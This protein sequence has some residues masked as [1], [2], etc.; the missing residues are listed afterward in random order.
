M[1]KLGAVIG[2]SILAWSAAATET[3]A[4]QQGE[5]KGARTAM[6]FD[7]SRPLSEM[8]KDVPPTMQ[9]DF[10]GDM[11]FD[12]GPSD[13]IYGP[14]T[15]DRSV[16]ERVG[17]LAIPAPAA[18]FNVGVGTANPPDPVGDVGPNHYVRMANA[19]FQIF[20]KAGAPLSNSAPINTL[21]AG[22]GGACETENAGDPIVLYDQLAD[23]W[24]LTQFSDS[25]GP[26]FF[27]CVAL[28]TSPDPLGTY[29]RWAFMTPSFPDYPKYGVWSNAY[30]IST[31]EVNSSQIGAIGV[32][33]AAMIAGNPTPTLIEFRVPVNQFSGDGLLPTDIDGTRLPPTGAPAY[34]IGAMDN[35]GPYGATQDA[36]NVWELN[37]NFATPA[38]SSF[39]LVKTVAISPYDTIFP[40]NGRACIPQPNNLGGVDILSY[41]QR[42]TNRAA[43][44]N[45]GSYQSIVTNQSV[46]AG[47]GIAGVRWWEIRNPGAN[48]VLYQDSTF[49]PGLT[50]GVNRW[51]GSI[52]QDASGNTGLGYSSVSLTEFPGIRYTGRLEH[53]PL[54]Q[55]SQGEGVFVT[56]AGGLTA[57]TK[58]WGDYT[59]MNIDPTD[60][61][62]FWFIN[63]YFPTSGTQWTLRAGSFKFPDCG[64]PNFGVAAVP[65]T[66]TLC[67]GTTANITVDAHGYNGFAGTANLSVTGAPAGTTTSF[68]PA[69]IGSVPGSSTLSIAN[70]AGVTAGN[71]TL[72]ITGQSGAL[73]RSRSVDVQFVTANLLAPSL[74]APAAGATGVSVQPLLSWSAVAESQSYRVEVATDA[75]F[76]NI[77][78]TSAATT[79][80]SLQLGPILTGGTQYFWRVR[81]GNLCGQGAFA[82]GSFRTRPAPG[83]CDA[84]ERLVTGF[85]DNMESGL[86]GWTVSPATAP[87][88]SQSTT[89]ANSPVNSWFAPDVT[90][91]SEQLLISPPISIAATQTALSLRFSHRFDMEPNGAGCFDGG[92]VEFSNDNGTTWQ[93][94]P[95]SSVLEGFYTG[96]LGNGQPAWCGT[97]NTFGNVSFDVVGLAGRTV[98]LRFHQSTDSGVGSP[99]GWFVD[100]VRIEGCESLDVLLRNG[101]E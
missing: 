85:S 97:R 13:K 67:A 86:N 24:L 38:S 80:T 21:F 30:L 83:Q 52:A 55:M 94:L 66:Q 14:Q 33:R 37:L 92:Y 42:P 93:P 56:G 88:W 90:T 32:D 79:A 1:F 7:V 76:N 12:P 9:L 50:D 29:F 10:D 35:G 98:R 2:L 48:S 41:R 100:D 49:A 25:T 4:V 27:N 91:P 60:D 75:G 65:L 73:T 70:T 47:T 22:F 62:T 81:A 82:S 58:R 68:S 57:A 23:R 71:Y 46:E 54:N 3:Q 40:C 18:N 95:A 51:M 43:Y 87:T 84:T 64:T 99:T 16:Q 61:C 5:F 39:T 89:A 34:F 28:S 17:P 74:L 77:V 8:L 101:F 72:A 69:T 15:P 31:R 11:M 19:S 26:G 63:E 59:S 20:S 45:Y 78:F 36:L 44:R 96:N 53:D 6:R